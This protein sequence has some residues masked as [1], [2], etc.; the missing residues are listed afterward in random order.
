MKSAVLSFIFLL[1]AV[2]GASLRKVEQEQHD[3]D[4]RPL[5]PQRR[6]LD[7][8]RGDIIPGSYIVTMKQNTEPDGKSGKKTSRM[9]HLYTFSRSSIYIFVQQVWPWNLSKSLESQRD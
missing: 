3:G 1:T 9:A 5:P 4:E 8:Q 2:N 6:R 7:H